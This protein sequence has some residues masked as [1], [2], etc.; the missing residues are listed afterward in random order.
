MKS[1]S[2]QTRDTYIAILR[3]FINI[4]ADCLLPNINK[5]LLLRDAAVDASDD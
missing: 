1:A 3:T 2:E 4:F 5:I